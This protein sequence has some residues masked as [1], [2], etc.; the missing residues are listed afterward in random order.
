MRDRTLLKWNKKNKTLC[1]VS[2]NLYLRK[3]LNALNI[4]RI[5]VKNYAAESCF[6]YLARHT[7]VKCNVVVGWLS[8]SLGQQNQKHLE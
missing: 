5:N 8:N 1:L 6:A 4:H 2:L 7:Q 3:A